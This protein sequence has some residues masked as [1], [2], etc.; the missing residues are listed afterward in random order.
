MQYQDTWV[1]I[2]HSIV[3]NNYE[4]VQRNASTGRFRAFV[5]DSP[6]SKEV[7]VGTFD[8]ASIAAVERALFLHNTKRSA[9]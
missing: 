7:E 4:G 3:S 6:H 2:E 8:T 1:S 5:R 9:W